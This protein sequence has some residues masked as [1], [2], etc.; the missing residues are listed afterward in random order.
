[1]ENREAILVRF[2]TALNQALHEKFGEIPSTSQF[3]RMFN[4]LTRPEDYITR[5]TA[6]KWLKGLAYPEVSRLHL[7]TQWL[8]LSPTD[9]LAATPPDKAPTATK[10]VAMPVRL[11]QQTLDA[12]SAHIAVIDAEGVICQVNQSWSEFAKGNGAPASLQFGV[13][14]NYL[15]ACDAS[16]AKR[17]STAKAMAAGIRAVLKGSLQE[18][19]LKY[20]CHSP[21]ERRWFVAHTTGFEHAG[22]RYAVVSHE[23]VSEENWHKLDFPQPPAP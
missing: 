17:D 18:F 16:R 23:S 19:A 12:L 6:R 9:I 13:G 3:A 7:L 1:M 2:A 20:P 8:G 22:R 11:A 4:A 15:K 10:G 14:V 5:E 21:T